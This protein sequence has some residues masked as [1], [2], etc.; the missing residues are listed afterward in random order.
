LC[1]IKQDACHAEE[2]RHASC[3]QCYRSLQREHCLF[4]Q[5]QFSVAVL[6]ALTFAVVLIA[7][8]AAIRFLNRTIRERQ[9]WRPTLRIGRNRPPAD[10]RYKQK[11]ET[12]G[13]NFR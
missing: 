1:R 8:A 10:E 7:F 9:R 6:A 2:Y 3:F 13:A 5:T 4:D 12:E 11:D